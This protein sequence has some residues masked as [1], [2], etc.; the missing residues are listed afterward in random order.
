MTRAGA[1]D[2]GGA[3]VRTHGLTMRFGGV[4]AV[5]GVDFS[6]RRGELR[7]LIGPNGAGKST[8]FRCLSGQYAP[9]SG[10]VWLAGRQVTGQPVHA[11]ARQGVG[12]KTQVPQLMNG[13]P[14]HEN[15]WLAAKFFHPPGVAGDKASAMLRQLGLEGLS[16]RT[17]GEL[18]HGQRQL[19]ELG[20]VLVT[21]PWLVLLDEPAGGLAQHEIE[22][23]AEA[24]RMAN[25]SATVIVVEHDMRFIRNIAESVTVF[26]QGK[27]LVEGQADAV[28]ADERVKNVYLGKKPR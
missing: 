4:V 6:L 24:V 14:V 15:L 16:S 13:L 21:E 26:H 10:E 23:M 8:F 25:R 7:C 20:V 27:I 5:D 3:V 2:D 12:I 17:A 9:T 11:I 28:L 19:V 22:R 1:S 18:A